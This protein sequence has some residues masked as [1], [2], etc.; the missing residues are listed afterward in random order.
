MQPYFRFFIDALGVS[1]ATFLMNVAAGKCVKVY[2]ASGTSNKALERDEE[3]EC[4]LL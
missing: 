1:Y 3:A 2:R 4:G